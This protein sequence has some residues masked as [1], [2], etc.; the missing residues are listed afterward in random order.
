MKH[1]AFLYDVA[2]YMSLGTSF[3]EVTAGSR[4]PWDGMS[5]LLEGIPPSVFLEPFVSIGSHMM[6]RKVRRVY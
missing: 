3:P 1:P 4:S 6:A 5:V 2:S